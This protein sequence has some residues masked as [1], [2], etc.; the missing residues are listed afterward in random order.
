MIRSRPWRPYGE[1]GG[2]CAGE[3]GGGGG[4]GLGEGGEGYLILRL[5]VG[6]PLPSVRG[7]GGNRYS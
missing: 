1:G 6:F 2:T 3:C 7:K 4:G 5:T